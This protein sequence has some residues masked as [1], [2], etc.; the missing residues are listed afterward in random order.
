MLTG[1]TQKDSGKII[2]NGMDIDTDLDDV[3][4]CVGICLQQD[5]LY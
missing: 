1:L 2:V 3:R 4:K 5:V